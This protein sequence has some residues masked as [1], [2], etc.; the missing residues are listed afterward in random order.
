MYLEKTRAELPV[1]DA[2]LASSQ[3]PCAQAPWAKLRKYLAVGSIVVL[4]QSGAILLLAM[5]ERSRRRN[6]QII[7]RLVQRINEVREEEQRHIGRELHDNIGQRLSLLSI[8]LGC[9]LDPGVNSRSLE[10]TAELIKELDDLIREV[11]DLSHSLHSTKLEYLG[12]DD[13]LA[14]MC[15]DIAQQQDI[16]IK[17][18][19][20][21]AHG[22]ESPKVSLSFYRVAQE[23]LNNVIKHSGAAHVQITLTR[24]E[25]RLLMQISD[26]GV[27][28][29]TGSSGYGLGLTSM[30][31]RALS[32]HGRL[33]VWSRLG[34][35]TSILAEAPRNPYNQHGFESLSDIPAP[36]ELDSHAS[37]LTT[38]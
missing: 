4:A 33:S 31:E 5:A 14:E 38:L 37:Q 17:F 16:D 1:A 2:P 10:D 15:R 34:R 3:A 30:E 18:Q 29:D 11:H 35:G 8:R 24:T 32:V 21:G 6:R 19:L 12:L 27:G 13:A 25:D 9:L 26:D 20:Q 36:G 22:R 23:G 7:R 28:F